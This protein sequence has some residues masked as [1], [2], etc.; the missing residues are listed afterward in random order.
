MLILLLTLPCVLCTGLKAITYGN[1]QPVQT[2]V[3]FAAPSATYEPA[4]NDTEGIDHVQFQQTPQDQTTKYLDLLSH[5][6][7]DYQDSQDENQDELGR[8]FPIG[9]TTDRT[10][11]RRADFLQKRQRAPA[12][13]GYMQIDCLVA[14]EVCQN[15]GWYQ[16]CLYGGRVVNYTEGRASDDK[17]NRVQS[18]VRTSDGTPCKTW[19]FGQILWDTY[20]FNEINPRP[21]ESKLETDEWPMA[22]MT[23]AAFDPTANPPQ[24]SLRCMTGTSNG[25]GGKAWTNFRRGHGHYNQGGK[26]THF[27]PSLGPSQALVP[28]DT[29]QVQLNFESFNATHESLRKYESVDPSSE[30][31]A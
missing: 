24:R 21:A 23:N 27:R 7:S 10:L 26:W 18:G 20:P 1:I 30:M 29:F 28:G 19:P 8:Y 12:F 22:S 6:A 5:V 3:A 11:V 25:G 31:M 16:N 4:L 13:Q 14:P 15:V 9:S 17:T 2:L